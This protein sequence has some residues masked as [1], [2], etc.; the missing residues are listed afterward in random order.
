MSGIIQMIMGV[1][2]SSKMPKISDGGII[3]MYYQYPNHL[4]TTNKGLSWSSTGTFGETYGGMSSGD[5]FLH[6]YDSHRKYNFDLSSFT[7]L[8]GGS[9]GV[10]RYHVNPNTGVIMRQ[11]YNSIERSTDGGTTWTTVHTRSPGSS[12]SNGFHYGN[13]VWFHNYT[14]TNASPRVVYSLRST[15]DGLTW[16]SS[17]ISGLPTSSNNF[18]GHSFYANGYHYFR[19]PDDKVYRSTNALTWTQISSGYFNTNNYGQANLPFFIN[20]YIY[21]MSSGQIYR[22]ADAITWETFGNPIS[23]VRSVG[24]MNG[25]WVALCGSYDGNSGT[26]YTSSD[27][28]QTWTLRQTLSGAGS[29]YGVTVYGLN[30]HYTL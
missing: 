1:L 17:G 30:Q 9:G 19:H 18:S 8:T 2:S 22:S 29:G 26:I 15:D 16:S 23:N 11:V 24:Y 28:A 12:F 25:N 21:V 13:G 7:S 14:D 20:G 6:V 4:Y 5:V 3:E 10:V 27:N